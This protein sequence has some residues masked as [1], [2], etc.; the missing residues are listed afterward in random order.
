MK[1]KNL[2]L[3]LESKEAYEKFLKENS[4]SFFCAAFTIL[5]LKNKTSQLQ[6]DYFIPELNRIASFEHPFEQFR[7]YEDEVKE[8]KIQEAS[9]T[10]D[11]IDLERFCKNIL[12]EKEIKITPTKIIAILKEN[13]WNITCM[14]DFLGIIRIKINSS[15]GELISIDKG[16]LIDFI[17]VKKS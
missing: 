11:I 8:M 10:V 15:S 4:S 2:I 6:L 16:S 1:L 17:G 9:P 14:D 7:I 12:E 5:D 13:L 3:E